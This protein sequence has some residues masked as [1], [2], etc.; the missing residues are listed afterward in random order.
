MF[1]SEGVDRITT[2]YTGA[3]AKNG[4]S[5]LFRANTGIPDA[6]TGAFPCPI[7]VEKVVMEVQQSVA[8]HVRSRQLYMENS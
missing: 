2:L 8:L 4:T 7:S 6:F 5:M 1:L 3:A